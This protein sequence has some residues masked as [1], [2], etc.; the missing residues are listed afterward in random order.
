MCKFW[1]IYQ[2]FCNGYLEWSVLFEISQPDRRGKEFGIRCGSM[3]PGP[4]HKPQNPISLTYPVHHVRLMQSPLPTT[5][6]TTG[7]R[8]ATGKT[9]PTGCRAAAG[10][11]FFMVVSAFTV[12]KNMK[13]KG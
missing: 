6:C 10:K 4:L 5:T 9:G 11:K 1:Q 13:Q 3:M 7:S 12:L 8:D 2:D